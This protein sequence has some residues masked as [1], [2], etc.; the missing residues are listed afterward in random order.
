MRNFDP[1]FG[2]RYCEFI[3]EAEMVAVCYASLA[4]VYVYYSCCRHNNLI[5]F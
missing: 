2:V 1:S 4:E 5:V 3:I